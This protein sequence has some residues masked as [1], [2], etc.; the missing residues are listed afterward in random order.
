MARTEIDPSD[1][2]HLYR[3]IAEILRGQI[4]SGKLPARGFLPSKLTLTRRFSVSARTID[5]ATGLLKDW[6]YIRTVIGRG[7][8]ILPP[9]ER[10]QAHPRRRA[11][12]R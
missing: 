9:E 6:G 10:G 8:W 11:T 3:Q 1:S 2:M 4:E 5:S 7:F 12:D